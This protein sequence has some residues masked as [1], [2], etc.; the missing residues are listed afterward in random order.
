MI[1]GT[2][3]CCSDCARPARGLGWGWSDLNPITAFKD[4]GNAVVDA[5]GSVALN[6]ATKA[7]DFSKKTF[8]TTLA[9]GHT[10]RQLSQASQEASGDPADIPAVSYLPLALGGVAAAGLLLWAF[11]GRKKTTT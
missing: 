2:G 9:A 4:V 3:A 5:V 11:K 1:V 6:A 7:D 8:E 10:V